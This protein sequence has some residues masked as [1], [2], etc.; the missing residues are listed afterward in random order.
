MF[1]D[2]E[3]KQKDILLHCRTSVARGTSYHFVIAVFYRAM[4]V[5]EIPDETDTKKIL[6][7]FSLEE[8][9]ETTRT[10]CT[11]TTRMKTIE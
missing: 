7:A 1:H 5:A 6:T 4:F 9:E 10:P 8:L 2:R 3:D 11:R